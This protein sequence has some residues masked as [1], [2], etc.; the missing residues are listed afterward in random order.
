MHATFSCAPTGYNG[1]QEAVAGALR[2]E[3]AVEYLRDMGK[4]TH[5]QFEG[6]LAGMVRAMG[7]EGE[8]EESSSRIQS[9]KGNSYTGLG[10]M[11]HAA[12]LP[13]EDST[14]T[15]EDSVGPR[16]P[17]ASVPATALASGD[18]EASSPAAAMSKP[19][20]PKAEPESSRL[21]QALDELAAEEDD[22]P[23]IRSRRYAPPAAPVRQRS[24]SVPRSSSICSNNKQS[25][26][27]MEE[28]Y[29]T[30]G[31]AGAGGEAAADGQRHRGR[32]RSSSQGRGG[33]REG[34]QEGEEDDTPMLPEHEGACRG[35]RRPGVARGRAQCPWDD[36]PAAAE[37]ASGQQGTE[38][39]QEG[40]CGLLRSSR[41]SRD[42][43]SELAKSV[44]LMMAKHSKKAAAHPMSTSVPSLPP[45]PSAASGLLRP[46]APRPTPPPI[47]HAPSHQ[48]G[49]PALCS[50]FAA[51]SRGCS[52][53]RRMVPFA[54]SRDPSP[55]RGFSGA[56]PNYP[57]PRSLAASEIV[58]AGRAFSRNASPAARRLSGLDPADLSLQQQ[59]E[60]AAAGGKSFTSRGPSPARRL[61][62]LASRDPSPARPIM[63]A[64]GAA[65]AGAAGG[66][67]EAAAVPAS[68]PPRPLAPAEMVAA[69]VAALANQR[70]PA[71][72]SPSGTPPRP[73]RSEKSEVGESPEG[74]RRPP[75]SGRVAPS[76]SRM[77]NS[78][79]DGGASA[80]LAP[81]LP[82]AQRGLSP[83][84]ASQ[85]GS[86]RQGEAA[87]EQEL[88]PEEQ[89]LAEISWKLPGRFGRHASPAR[90]SVVCTSRDASPQSR[91]V[92]GLAT[93]PS[94]QPSLP[95]T[96]V[97]GASSEASSRSL[98]G[99][100][101]PKLPSG[102]ATWSHGGGGA[103][104]PGGA[105]LVAG[106]S[107]SG[108][109]RHI[110][111]AEREA[112]GGPLPQLTQ[113]LIYRN[114]DASFDMV[115]PSQPGK[116][117][118]NVMELP[119]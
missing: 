79:Q 109:H 46:P 6:R 18:S 40:G 43:T 101:L 92:H 108:P 112:M 103:G 15:S 72:D 20:R 37:A 62:R 48:E 65:G 54:G 113:R 34:G 23:I 24:S 82:R 19:P 107:P 4:H 93:E 16:T 3:L 44:D 38:E 76:S 45:L 119:E 104:L 84:R 11:L 12:A 39:E 85:Q 99:R 73:E 91:G 111:A 87:A 78:S 47:P 28:A 10:S 64:A 110:T 114:E 41:H 27:S 36:E 89:M 71:G 56:D 25:L 90:G 115:R 50:A 83:M 100:C 96:S 105:G 31:P 58:E 26:A 59:A 9:H 68:L 8:P 1:Y 51:A 95:R 13:V 2:K 106:S 66:V 117:A 97:D 29:S 52:P 33:A 57:V 88:T 98:S 60:A 116:P 69:A 32:A 21:H 80:S 86:S 63:G 7:E 14:N 94:P 75:R 49:E 5:V 42:M 70:V 61:D 55:A 30:A 81:A 118:R 53:A 35:V 17:P 102:K 22:G 67:A 77:A 74:P